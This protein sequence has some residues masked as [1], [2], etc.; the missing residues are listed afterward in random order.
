MIQRIGLVGHAGACAWMTV[1]ANSASAANASRCSCMVFPPWKRTMDG[2][3]WSVANLMLAASRAHLPQ[4]IP[5]AASFKGNLT[6]N[7]RFHV[8]L[9]R[10]PTILPLSMDPG[11]TSPV[12]FSTLKSFG[13]STTH[14]TPLSIDFAW[15][16][17]KSIDLTACA[18]AVAN[19]PPGQNMIL[20]SVRCLPAL[21]PST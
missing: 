13:D 11:L 16:V 19:P 5:A 10:A 12:I 20:T 14:C 21:A 3:H 17:L 8:D 18:D 15:F 6:S 7:S 4:P 9:P 1:E 2:Q